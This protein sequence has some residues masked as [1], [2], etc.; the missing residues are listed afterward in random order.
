[1][2][3]YLA[4]P[5]KCP[6]FVLYKVS[7]KISH[8]KRTVQIQSNFGALS[9]LKAFYL[10]LIKFSFIYIFGNTLST[11]FSVNIRFF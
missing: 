11:F 8:G 4:L 1:M 9:N 10:K 5:T 6:K 2:I 3:S 7:V